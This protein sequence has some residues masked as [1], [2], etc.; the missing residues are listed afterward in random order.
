[1][2]GAS[3][4]T[5]GQHG[6]SAPSRELDEK[7]G[8][9]RQL[10]V[11]LLNLL[12][13][14]EHPISPPQRRLLLSSLVEWVLGAARVVPLVIAIEDLHWAD[15][16]TLE[17]IQLL[18]EQAGS[19]P[20]LLLCTA[21]PEFRATWLAQTQIT[22]RPLSPHNTR[23]MVERVAGQKTLPDKLVTTVVER[24]GGVPLFV[25]ELARAVLESDTVRPTARE[26][27]VTLH[28]SLMA[29]L[30]RLGL[31][32]EVLQIG[33]VMGTDFSYE[34]LQAVH[35][36]AEQDLQEALQKAADAELVYVHGSAPDATYQ[37]RHALIRDAAY[38]ALLKSKR[39]ELHT[40]IAQT[41][42][43][44]FS[45]QAAA[46]P[47]IL[48]YHYT[49]AGL[50]AQAVR[51]WRR[52]GQK[53][54]ER[55]ANVEA[56]AQLR[57]GMELLNALPLNS[58]R[59][60]EEVKLQIALTTP[61]IATAGYTGPEVEK[62]SSRALEL[63]RQLGETPQLFAALGS[64]ES[65]YFNRGEVEIAL[66]LSKQMFHLASTQ[67]DPVLLL[68]AHYALGFSLAWQGDLR[69][70]R[71]HLERS[72]SLYDK[73]RAGTYGFVQ[74]PGPS[75]MAQLSHVV[76]SL[77]YPQQALARMRDGIAQARNLSHPFTLALVLG[78]AAS[79]HWSRGEK[80]IAQELWREEAALSSEQ[81]FKALLAAASLRMGFYQ[82]EEGGAED[83]LAKMHTALASLTESLVIDIPYGLIFLA[84]A[85][86]KVGQLDQGLARIDEALALAKRTPKFADLPLLYVTNGQLLLMKSPS[87]LRKAKQCFSTAIEIARGQK[88]KSDELRAS[89]PMARV[90]AQQG[91]RKQARTMLAEIYNWF[92]EGFDT[93]DLKDAKTLLDELAT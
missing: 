47:E 86:G 90:L 11:A 71:D 67:Q 89:I 25:E 77:G 48:A 42:E 79:L 82:V 2:N 37:F 76:H 32:K 45:H 83:G 36:I 49:E 75:A 16:S 69:S 24:T 80:L 64:L 60:I 63:C 34:V 92:T 18:L 14:M 66:E 73:R 10:A 3:I 51:Y 15:P 17:L 12:N 33:A 5:Y 4:K 31:A 84:L 57:K 9:T 53:A 22:L 1:M 19:A 26:I 39:R 78:Y 61:L 29:R 43:E 65:I 74:D 58:E 21:R 68:W 52:A 46:H 20:L 93:A 55:S 8:P 40:R 91:R 28:D 27:P 54:S 6:K 72:I 62:A 41:I 44:R 35:P 87:G 7:L 30:D 23:M 59:L 70:S 85:L 13:P 56:I 81:G 38:E 88:A 50:V